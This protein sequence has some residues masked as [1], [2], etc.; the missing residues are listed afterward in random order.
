MG[1]RTAVSVAIGLATGYGMALLLGAPVMLGLMVGG[2]QGM[3]TSITVGE[4]TSTGLAKW[5]LWTVVPFGCGLVVSVALHDYHTVELVL[6]LVVL[7]SQP[8][9]VQIGKI[10][11]YSAAVFFSAYLVGLIVHI[12]Q[13]AVGSLLVTACAVVVALA[14]GRLVLCHPTPREDLIRTQRAFVVEA[15]RLAEAAA[16]ALD[17]DADP[18]RANKRMRRAMGRMNVVTLTVDGRLAQPEAA[19][20][21]AAAEELHQYLFDAELALEGIGRAV[22]EM[23]RDTMSSALRETLVVALLLTRDTPLGRADALRP[24]ADRIRRQAEVA[25]GRDM[26]QTCAL[27]RRVADLLDSLADSL[28]HWLDLGRA[29]PMA[30]EKVPFQTAVALEAGKP[31]GVGPAVERVAANGHG[32]RLSPAVRAALQ[33]A[34]AGTVVL[35][36]AEWINSDKFYWG[37]VGVLVALTGTSTTHERVRKTGRRLAGTVLGAILGIA[38]HD[39]IGPGHVLWSLVV[40]TVAISIGAWGMQRNYAI[41]VTGLVTA[42]VQ[43]YSFTSPGNLSWLLTQRLIDNGVGMALATLAA[44]LILPLSTARIMREAE[45][46]YLDAVKQLL[47]RTRERWNDPKNPVRLRGAARSVGAA[48]YQVQ[49][50]VKPLVR[51]PRGVRGR[52]GDDLL[53]LLDNA[54][55]HA[56]RLAR[57]ADIDLE[58]RLRAEINKVLDTF[59]TSLDAL[60]RHIT[61]HGGPTS[62]FDGDVWTRVAPL[63]REVQA[64]LSTP[65]G[66][67]ETH[68]YAALGELAALDENLARLSSLRGMPT[69]PLAEEGTPTAPP[70]TRWRACSRAATP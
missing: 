22:Q 43:L 34:V 58:P 9:V 70:A 18:Q 45:R 21:P 57:S 44:A 11:L 5:L 54:T 1:W 40:I 15:R 42:L 38:L 12:P 61:H 2:M 66:A 30:G 69:G 36:I 16:S 67:G 31:T 59:T 56:H 25:E 63:I 6:L 68:L 65:A 33:A 47:E 23:E 39:L 17:L 4:N 46:G 51:L 55:R 20:D 8:Y 52:S 14:A 50:T 62:R 24:A 13:E 48:N 64:E 41:W 26:K 35:P 10:G 29:A 49:S 27:A 60:G 3:I 37:I 7:A 32:A 53:A 28:A 19:A